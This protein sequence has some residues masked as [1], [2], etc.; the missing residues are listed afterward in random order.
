MLNELLAVSTRGCSATAGG[1]GSS[2]WCC[3]SSN[4]QKDVID[5]N[6]SV[7]MRICLC[8]NKTEVE[9]AG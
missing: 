3:E 1:V 2:S 7:M 5:D 4:L 9:C 6:V 8:A